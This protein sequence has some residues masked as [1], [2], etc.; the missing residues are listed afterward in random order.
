MC[1]MAKTLRG[2]AML[3]LKGWSECASSWLA[4]YVQSCSILAS[5]TRVLRSET[6]SSLILLSF[7]I[8]YEAPLSASF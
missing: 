2:S 5:Y 4:P 6:Y 8:S 3:T 7:C 1:E